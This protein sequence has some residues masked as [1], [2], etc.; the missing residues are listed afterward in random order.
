[1]KEHIN[2]W[3]K[4]QIKAILQT[5]LW[6]LIVAC[7]ILFAPASMTVCAATQ[8]SYYV[9]PGGSDINPGTLAQPFL[10]VTKARDVVR[11]VNR[12]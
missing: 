12:P 11:T 2:G 8:A 1:M 10:T 4:F 9:S 3:N 6:L 5:T 7:S